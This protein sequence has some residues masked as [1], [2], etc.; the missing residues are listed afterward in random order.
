MYTTNTNEAVVIV[1]HYNNISVK[2]TYAQLWLTR[3][4]Y[5]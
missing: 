1:Q 2:K 3:Y 5:D 4:T